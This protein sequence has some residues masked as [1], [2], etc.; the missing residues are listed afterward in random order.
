MAS[1]PH[2]L[3]WMCHPSCI[4]FARTQLSAEEVAGRSVLEVGSLD[5]NGSVR[6]FVEAL[7][8]AVY[9]GVDIEHGPRVD[10]VC[11]VTQLTERFG[12]G[13]FD[14]VISTELVEHVRDWRTAFSNL[15][16]VLR[17][18]GTILVTTRS[19][20]FAMHGWPH[21]YWRYEPEDMHRIFEDFEAVVVERD[22]EA[23]GVFVKARK[24]VRPVDGA[25]L[26]DIEL[27]SIA[28]RRRS[29]KISKLVDFLHRPRFGSLRK[30][31]ALRDR[32][33]RRKENRSD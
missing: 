4:T 13:H 5:V 11:D 14:L 28:V 7:R 15:K 17:P 19:E 29:K 10:E 32:W 22:P 8:P 33:R 23:P 20:G 16:R 18:G 2:M 27:Y 6:P 25:P 1:S 30:Q 26:S 24:P 3:C 9:V 21:D 12:E 31:L